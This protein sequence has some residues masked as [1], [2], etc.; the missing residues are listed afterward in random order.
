MARRQRQETQPQVQ[1]N[2]TIDKNALLQALQKVMPGIAAKQILEQSDHFV[3]DNNK[4]WS[5]NDQIFI[6]QKYDSPIKG[7]IKA[8]EFYKMIEKITNQEISISQEENLLTIK[9]GNDEFSAVVNV[10]DIKLKTDTIDIPAHNSDKWNALPS[11]FIEAIQFCM[12]SA[13]KNMMTP[14][15][16]CIYIS[17]DNAISCDG[18]RG[19]R[20]NLNEK[21]PV[22]FLLKSD[23][24][25][26][27]GIYN[28][29]KYAVSD[30]WIHFINNE[31]TICSVRVSATSYPEKIWDFFD[32][33]G[34][35]IKL[36][37]GF[38]KAVSQS[39]TFVVEDFDQDKCVHISIADNQITCTGQ[40]VLGK[41]DV[42]KKIEYTRE[43]IDI[44]VHPKLLQDIL[45][46]TN[47]VE[48]G[49]RLRF[50]SDNFDHCIVLSVVEE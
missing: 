20:Y 33:S 26:Y 11:N 38:D 6:S 31:N 45:K 28:P 16:N 46:K 13:S 1:T 43:K 32:C 30:N 22:E 37:E 14:E 24:A 9:A 35:E 18:F 5:Y 2:Q 29:V 36:P 44:D 10:A 25:K 19:T 42:K 4:I 48:I 8:Q 27:M 15:F 41:I 17:E 40:G 34:V 23:A 7:A 12:F 39:E 3:F 49:E 50:V 47:T 21:V